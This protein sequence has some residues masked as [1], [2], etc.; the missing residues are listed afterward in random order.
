MSTTTAHSTASSYAT[1][2]SSLASELGTSLVITD[3]SLRSRS[4]A[5]LRDSSEVLEEDIE[6]AV[7]YDQYFLGQY[8]FSLLDWMVPYQQVQSH[9]VPSLSGTGEREQGDGPYEL[10]T[11]NI[12][13]T[14]V[15]SI[16]PERDPHTPVAGRLESNER[17]PDGSRNM[18][19]KPMWPMDWNPTKE[20]NIVIFPDMVVLPAD[21]IE[22]EN[23]AHVEALG[24]AA[25]LEIDRCLWRVGSRHDLYEAFVNPVLVPIRILDCFIQLY[26]E[27]FH[28]LFPMLH[29]P[30]F[31]ASEAPWQLSLAVAAVG[32]QYSKVANSRAYA[33]VLQELLRRALSETASKFRGSAAAGMLNR[34]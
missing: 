25:Y 12:G 17:Q 23:L 8:G 16:T 28:P 5:E 21:I 33:N 1:T 13:I 4:Q 15:P 20:D 9:A 14:D 31:S 19:R 3:E 7:F 18:A 24:D 26:F 6:S 32:C 27:Y 22:T 29:K 30:S 34:A 2:S 10:Y 11:M